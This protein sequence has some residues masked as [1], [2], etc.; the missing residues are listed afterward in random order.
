MLN[1]IRNT[2]ITGLT[3]QTLSTD[4]YWDKAPT[5]SGTYI[6]LTEISDTSVHDKEP[7]A[8]LPGKARIQASVYGDDPVT[9]RNIKQALLSVIRTKRMITHDGHVWQ[10]ARMNFS[11]KAYNEASKRHSYIVDFFIDYFKS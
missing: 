7:I 5:A 11:E 1:L 2:I 6:T 4:V 9:I 10:S 3:E 8:N